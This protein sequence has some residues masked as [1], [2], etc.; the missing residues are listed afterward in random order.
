[1]SSPYATAEYKR[2]R[3]AVLEGSNY[4]C[5][6]CGGEA[7]EADHIIPVNHGGTNELSN[8]LPSCKKCNSSRQ[9]KVLVRMRYWNKRYA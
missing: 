7:N 6:Y 9:D 1:M 8:L 4:I 2:N 5:H 3:K